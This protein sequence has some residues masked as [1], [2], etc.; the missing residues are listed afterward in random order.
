MKL[1]KLLIA[2]LVVMS[3]LFFTAGLA[4]AGK[5]SAEHLGMMRV[6]TKVDTG[7]K[8]IYVGDKDIAYSSST[9]FFDRDGIKTSVSAVKKGL[10]ISFDYDK[11]KR[12]LSRPTATKVWIKSNYP[13]MIR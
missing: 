8:I 10:A 11:K 4:Q 13:L 6:V 7:K 3:G 9:V 1:K 2:S 5:I 12:Y